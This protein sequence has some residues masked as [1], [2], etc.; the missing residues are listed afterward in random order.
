[1][2]MINDMGDFLKTGGFVSEDAAGAGG[3]RHPRKS[4]AA[5]QRKKL[6]FGGLPSGEFLIQSIKLI[7]PI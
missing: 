6:G 5:A 1:M 7:Y 2:T 3:L 4:A